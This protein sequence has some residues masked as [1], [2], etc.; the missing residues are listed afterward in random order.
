MMG[1]AIADRVPWY[2]IELSRD[3]KLL[4]FYQRQLLLQAQLLMAGSIIIGN[5]I[6]I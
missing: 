4:I 6:G 5:V 3:S 1:L 2:D